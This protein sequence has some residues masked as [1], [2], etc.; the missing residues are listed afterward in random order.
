MRVILMLVLLLSACAAPDVHCDAHLQP[1]NTVSTISPNTHV[2]TA[3][4]HLP[5]RTPR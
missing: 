2:D 4:G 1:I 5:G 3:A